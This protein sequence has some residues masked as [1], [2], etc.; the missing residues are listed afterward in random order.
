MPDGRSGTDNVASQEISGKLLTFRYVIALAIMAL[1]AI[2]SHLAFNRV[3]HEH[4]GSAYLNQVNARQQVLAQRIARHALQYVHGDSAARDLLAAAVADFDRTHTALI[5]RITD[6]RVPVRARKAL[7]QVY[8]DPRNLHSEVTEFIAAGQRVLAA[9][10]P[11]AV[12]ADVALLQR[13]ADGT[14]ERDLKHVVDIYEKSSLAQLIQ[15]DKMQNALLVLVFLALTME[16]AIIFQPMVR[17]I[18]RYTA[19]LLK[20]A[21]TDPLTGLLNRRSFM[22]RGFAA[23]RESRREGKPSTL[24]TIDADYFKRVNDTHGHATGDEVLR[25]MAHTLQSNIRASDLL[26]RMGGEEFAV[27]MPDVDA[28]EARHLAERLRCAV[29]GLETITET[30]TIQFTISVGISA[31]RFDENDLLPALRRADQAL[32]SAKN[33]GRNRIVLAPPPEPVMVETAPV[34]ATV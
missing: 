5:E 9:S 20:L 10:A 33:A 34:R 25:A 2:A 27:L 4:G 21:T 12:A 8:F 18:T 32:Y 3:L 11:S 19:D 16:A 28:E 14:L 30:G 29:E 6:Q 23:A 13:H 26:G 22:D 1:I 17:R 31:I 15:L 7:Q 24:M